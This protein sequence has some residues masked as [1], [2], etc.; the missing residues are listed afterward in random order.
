MIKTFVNTSTLLKF[1][2]Q[3]AKYL[4]TGQ[5]SFD[6]IIDAQ[7]D[8]IVQDIKN[9]NIKIKKLCTPLVLSTTAK[10]DKIERSLFVINATSFTPTAKVKIWGCDT[11]SGTYEEISETTIAS[12]GE[13]PVNLTQLYYFYKITTSGTITATYSLYETSFVYAHIYKSLEQIYR[14]KQS[15]VDSNSKDKAEQYNQ[16]YEK[17]IEKIIFSYDEDG[18][19]EPT[20]DE[21]LTLKTITTLF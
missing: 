18:D 19:G 8:I 5:T 14:A 21:S 17:E 3:L 2:D 7:K 13:T 20:E 1:E 11:E 12:T 16:M 10:E 9:R 6:S 4:A 15:R